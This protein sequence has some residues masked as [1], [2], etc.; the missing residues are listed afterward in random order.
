MRKLVL[1]LIFKSTQPLPE[2]ACY[3]IGLAVDWLF[4]VPSPRQPE[5]SCCTDHLA[6]EDE[7]GGRMNWRRGLFHL[8]V[9]LSTVWAVYCA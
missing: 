7:G 6:S 2:V 3:R 5:P 9:G 8:W 1:A 4:V